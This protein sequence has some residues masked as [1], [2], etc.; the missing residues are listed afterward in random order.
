[1]EYQFDKENVENQLETYSIH[2][3]ELML[4]PI[5]VSDCESNTSN[6]VLV[7]HDADRWSDKFL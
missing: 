3:K 4:E 6:F 7:C 2:D 1:M 5:F